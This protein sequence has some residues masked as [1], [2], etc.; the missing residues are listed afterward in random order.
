MSPERGIPMEAAEVRWPY[1]PP[2]WDPIPWWFLDR[3]KLVQIIAVQLEGRI[4]AL[5]REIVQ[6]RKIHEIV[7]GK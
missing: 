2:C 4:A 7:V 1:P 6:M 5:E 3:E